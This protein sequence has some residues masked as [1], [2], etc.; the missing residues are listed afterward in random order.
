MKVYIFLPKFLYLDPCLIK[1]QIKYDNIMF[2]AAYNQSDCPLIDK[3]LS[4]N[5]IF[6]YN[7]VSEGNWENCGKLCNENLL[8]K[9]WTLELGRCWLKDKHSEEINSIGSI[10]GTR[11][12]PLSTGKNVLIHWGP[13]CWGWCVSFQAHYTGPGSHLKVSCKI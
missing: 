10:S 1:Y 3:S 6:G 2:F 12:C 8:C 5:N 11:N 7:G 4:G 9:F 13:Y